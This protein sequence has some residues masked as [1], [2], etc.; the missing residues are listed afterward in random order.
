MNPADRSVMSGAPPPGSALRL[1][2]VEGATT[3]AR[4]WSQVVT[5]LP[6]L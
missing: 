2:A 3:P 4:S 6:A 5:S 1:V